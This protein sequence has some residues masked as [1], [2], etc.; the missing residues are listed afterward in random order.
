VIRKLALIMCSMNEMLKSLASY[1]S[2]T[3]MCKSEHRCFGETHKL[4]KQCSDAYIRCC[5]TLCSLND[6]GFNGLSYLKQLY[7]HTYAHKTDLEA[8]IRVL[9]S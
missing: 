1:S 9:K 4:R 6:N 3:H 8:Q 2:E 5:N 7:D